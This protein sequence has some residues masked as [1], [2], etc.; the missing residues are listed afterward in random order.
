M[1]FMLIKQMMI[2]VNGKKMKKVIG[3]KDAI[4]KEPEK[5]HL[6]KSDLQCFILFI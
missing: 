2:L 4:L 1:T 6:E 5:M 3:K